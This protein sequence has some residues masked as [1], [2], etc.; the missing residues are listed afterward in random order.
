MLDYTSEADDPAGSSEFFGDFADE[1]GF[2]GLDMP[3]GEEDPCLAALACHEPKV[4]ETGTVRAAINR[5]QWR[6]SNAH[7][8]VGRSTTG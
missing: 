1:G 8:A 7:G 4:R 6:R 5:W 2:D 3:A